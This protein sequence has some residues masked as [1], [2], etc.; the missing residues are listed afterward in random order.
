MKYS[1]MSFSCPE[2]S[3]ADLLATARK[4]GYD[5]V[6][7]RID[8]QHKHGVEVSASAET[9]SEFRSQAQASGIAIACVATSC[10]YANPAITQ[11]NIELTHQCIDLAADVGAP[12]I[13]VF[14]GALA[15]DQERAA[16]VQSVAKALGAV[17]EHARE[18]GVT[19]CMETHDAWCNPADVAAVMQAV[20]HA[21]IAVNWDIMHPVR[22]A[23]VTMDE[24]FTTLKSWI[25]HVHIHDGLLEAQGLLP[26]GQGAIDHK[27]A[28]ELLTSA[29]YS[30]FLSGE[31]IKWKDAYETHLPR[32]LAAMKYYEQTI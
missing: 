12:R 5:G 13:R 6:E 30:G 2:L 19:V 18:R 31:W 3:L 17:A 29:G 21:A 14:G 1:F 28:L 20:N 27:R 25:R 15:Q 10:L 32:E 16:A 22:R 8:A 24:V 9:R 7:P 26:I 11:A 4:F 23:R